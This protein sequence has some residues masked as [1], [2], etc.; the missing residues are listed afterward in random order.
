[1]ALRPLLEEAEAQQ[2]IDVLRSNFLDHDGT[3]TRR[4]AAFLVGRPDDEIQ[5][6][7]VGFIKRLLDQ[8]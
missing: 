4:V 1:V 5:A 6:D 8:L 2:A 7:V 3:G